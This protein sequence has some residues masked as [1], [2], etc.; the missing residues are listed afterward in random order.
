MI[1]SR[2]CCWAPVSANGSPATNASTSGPSTRCRIPDSSASNARLRATSPTCIRKNSSKMRRPFAA[3]SSAIDS[4]RWMA[5]RA[6]LRSRRSQRSRRASSSGSAKPRARHFASASRTR[7]RNCQVNT[8]ALPDWGYTGTITPVFSSATPARPTTSTT[9]FVICRLPRY[10]SSLPK[11]DASV[12]TLNCFSRQPWLKN[13][14]VSIEVPSCTTT[15][16]SARP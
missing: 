10:T 1:S 2:A 6:E 16:T 12:P 15:S 11:N 14:M 13:V 4:G 3:A 8:S 7:A 5:R 9:G